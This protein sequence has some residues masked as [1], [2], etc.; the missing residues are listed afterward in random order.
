M[1]KLTAITELINIKESLLAVSECEVAKQ[2]IAKEFDPAECDKELSRWWS[3]FAAD[4]HVGALW[5]N[6][7]R[8]M[9]F[10]KWYF[11]PLESQMKSK[12]ADRAEIGIYDIKL[13]HRWAFWYSKISEQ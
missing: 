10:Q 7:C 8:E 11:R 13:R 2:M 4:I 6:G 5:I 1:S 3:V 9:V 12:M